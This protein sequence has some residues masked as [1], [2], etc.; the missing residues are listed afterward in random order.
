MENIYSID[1]ERSLLIY[2]YR[3]S[4]YLRNISGESIGKPTILSSDHAAYLS[5]TIHQSTLYFAYQNTQGDLLVKSILD[6]VSLFRISAFETRNCCCPVLYS[7]GQ[8]LLLLYVIQNPLNNEYSIKC[9]FPLNNEKNCT[10]P[11]S[12]SEIPQLSGQADPNGLLLQIFTHSRQLVLWISTDFSVLSLEP[13]EPFKEK[14][15]QLQSELEEQREQSFELEQLCIQ[16]KR[17]FQKKLQEK[18]AVIQDISRQY[19]QLMD[20]A[21]KYRDDAKKWYDICQNL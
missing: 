12:F 8:E 21:Q 6:P 2:P 13:P 20:T 11:E 19:E 5:S 4:V 7:L 17:S 9:V 3:Q 14:I 18:D 16:Q 15:L 1:S 10:I